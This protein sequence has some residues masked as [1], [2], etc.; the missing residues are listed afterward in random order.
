MELL[1]IPVGCG[2]IADPCSIV[3][4]PC[5]NIADPWGIIG[6]PCGDGTIMAVEW[7]HLVHAPMPIVAKLT[8]HR[9]TFVK[10]HETLVKL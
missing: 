9:E 6:D 2:V 7:H 4:D 1:L 8:K 3:A 5:S 10:H